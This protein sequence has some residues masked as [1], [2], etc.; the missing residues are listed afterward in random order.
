LFRSAFYRAGT[1]LLDAGLAV[2]AS[3]ACL[4]LIQSVNKG[5]G[6]KITVS[7]PTT[8]SQNIII[9]ISKK[10][11]GAGA[12]MNPDGSTSISVTL[13]SGE[14]AGKSIMIEFKEIEG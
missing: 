7:D 10:L 3:R 12:I 13:P 4:L 11:K 14:N 1:V 9:K 5:S 6:Y 2:T 8:K